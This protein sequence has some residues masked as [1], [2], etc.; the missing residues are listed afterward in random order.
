MEAATNVAQVIADGDVSTRPESSLGADET[1][2][3]TASSAELTAEAAVE[4]TSTASE[5]ASTAVEPA[6]PEVTPLVVPAAV[7]DVVADATAVVVAGEPAPSDAPSSIP[8]L[9]PMDTPAPVDVPT[10]VVDVVAVVDETAGVVDAEPAPSYDASSVPLAAPADTSAPMDVPVAVAVVFTEPALSDAPSSS[11]SSQ[12]P[13]TAVKPA[14]AAAP[15]PAVPA[16]LKPAIVSKSVVAATKPKPTVTTA[17]PKPAANAAG[18]KH[19]VTAGAPKPAVTDAARKPPSK[20]KTVV[21]AARKE[22]EPPEALSSD[23]LQKRWLAFQKASQKAAV[24]RAAAEA[25]R[26]AA[27]AAVPPASK[28][29]EKGPAVVAEKSNAY[30]EW[31]KRKEAQL[32]AE[33]AREAA[34]FERICATIAERDAQRLEERK[35]KL[36]LRKASS[37]SPQRGSDSRAGLHGAKNVYFSYDDKPTAPALTAAPEPS[38]SSARVSTSRGDA[39]M[40][41]VLPSTASAAAVHAESMTT[42]DVNAVPARAGSPDI[43][44]LPPPSGGAM[45]LGFLGSTREASAVIEQSD[46]SRASFDLLALLPPTETLRVAD[47]AAPPMSGIDFMYSSK[48][49]GGESTAG[50]LDMHE[51]DPYR[52]AR[53]EALYRAP[54]SSELLVAALQGRALPAGMELELGA[55]QF[56][57]STTPPPSR[58]SARAR[59]GGAS[60]SRPQ[61]RSAVRVPVARPPWDD[62]FSGDSALSGGGRSG[63]AGAPI[64]DRE[65]TRAVTSNV[66]GS[67]SAKAP[68]TPAEKSPRRPISVSFDRLS[69]RLAVGERLGEDMTHKLLNA[70]GATDPET[71]RFVEASASARTARAAFNDERSLEAEALAGSSRGSLRARTAEGRSRAGS[72]RTT[73]TTMSPRD[74]RHN[75]ARPSTSDHSARSRHPQP[76]FRDDPPAVPSS[77]AAATLRALAPMV[78]DTIVLAAT[79]RA[80]FKRQGLSALNGAGTDADAEPVQTLGQFRDDATSAALKF[81]AAGQRNAIALQLT[82]A[83][84]YD[85]ALAAAAGGTPGVAVAM[86]SGVFPVRYAAE[87]TAGVLA[88]HVG[89]DAV[90]AAY[91]AARR[92]GADPRASASAR[93]ADDV[94]ASGPRSL[95]DD[96]NGGAF[97]DATRSIDLVGADVINKAMAAAAAAAERAIENALLSVRT[98]NFSAPSADAV[99]ARPYFAMPSPRADAATAPPSE[100]ALRS[101]RAADEAPLAPSSAPALR[102]FAVLVGNAVEPVP[103]EPALLV[104]TVPL[105]NGEGAQGSAAGDGP[106]GESARESAANEAGSGEA[107][108]THAVLTA[109]SEIASDKVSVAEQ[110]GTENATT[111]ANGG[112]SSTENVMTVPASSSSSETAPTSAA[113][114]PI[115]V[116]ESVTPASSS[117][118]APA[119]VAPSTS[120]AA[121]TEE[122]TSA[123]V[124]TTAAPALADENAGLD[125]RLLEIVDVDTLRRAT[126]D[127]AVR[128]I[129]SKI[130]KQLLSEFAKQHVPSMLSTLDSA[131]ERFASTPEK[132]W[133][134]CIKRHGDSAL[135]F[136][137]AV[138]SLIQRVP[139]AI[140]RAQLS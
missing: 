93:S 55:Q 127:D 54:N 22:S 82:D 91:A 71:V 20:A 77:V 138:T 136:S 42:F 52:L 63:G 19:V 108:Q 31:L 107:V 112:E 139:A 95:L 41:V 1:K 101:Q 64:N 29:P 132:L 67:P 130:H 65:L 16:A 89:A 128:S 14:V 50:L 74:A 79:G 70:V 123:A 17:T 126:T 51:V 72:P 96:K 102:P 44:T 133:A 33:K 110:R 12:L 25:K 66:S 125:A 119:L 69:L 39:R 100:D 86:G 80:A 92:A 62:H 90:A 61:S 105:A 124:L 129:Y 85:A 45:S 122:S 4:V 24:E 3:S 117:A 120:N 30:A 10:A 84:A 23:A 134:A 116:P 114:A 37:K 106:V 109:T 97:I 98:A 59:S 27:E 46:P 38:P 56:L 32:A 68:P 21:S 49:V 76:T 53:Q 81:A 34:E 35:S 60:G 47:G 11:V 83:A 94:F 2:L 28:A 87:A 78:D 121:A 15:K 40:S 8:A 48:E 26:A 115:E 13:A 137:N 103:V 5:S 43:M 57:Q 9:P 111:S 99:T 18:P 104:A 131:F 118:E 140:A 73:M 6:A 88:K 75:T 135:A 113:V 58:L 7:V 36:A